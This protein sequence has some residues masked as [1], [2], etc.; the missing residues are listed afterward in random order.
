MA[1]EDIDSDE[2]MLCIPIRLMI[3]PPV[4]RASPELAP[5][6]EHNSM[7]FADNDMVTE[8]ATAMAMFV[9]RKS[10]APS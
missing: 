6:Y 2:K 4:C 9:G 8:I 5:V 10:V 7:L 1:T 3:C